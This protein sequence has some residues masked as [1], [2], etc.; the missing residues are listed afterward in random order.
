MTKEKVST[1]SGHRVTILEIWE[2]RHPYTPITFTIPWPAHIVAKSPLD[3]S[4]D[5][6]KTS[7]KKVLFKNLSRDK[8]IKNI[9]GIQDKN[10]KRSNRHRK[11]NEMK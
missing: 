1:G 2:I 10:K 4:E 5:P 11:K 3:P 9:N 6:Q 8:S 7:K